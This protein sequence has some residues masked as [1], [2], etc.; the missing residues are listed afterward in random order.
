MNKV[1]NISPLLHQHLFVEMADAQCGEFDM[2][3][4]IESDFFLH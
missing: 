3:P 1:V 2:T 4:Y